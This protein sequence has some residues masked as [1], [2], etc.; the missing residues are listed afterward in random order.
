MNVTMQQSL[1]F[2][3][4]LQVSVEKFYVKRKKLK[5]LKVET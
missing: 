2:R 5:K 4:W 3:D 1:Y